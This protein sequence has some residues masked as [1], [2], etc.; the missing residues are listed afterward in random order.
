MRCCLIRVCRQRYRARRAGSIKESLGETGAAPAQRPGGRGA[1]SFRKVIWGMA[2]VTTEGLYRKLFRVGR[3]WETSSRERKV[4]NGRKSYLLCSLCLKM[5]FLPSF[6]M[7][8]SPDSKTKP[9]CE[10]NCVRLLFPRRL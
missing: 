9:Q 4:F 6:L 3:H 1:I 7:V 10:P 2:A 8:Y 5:K